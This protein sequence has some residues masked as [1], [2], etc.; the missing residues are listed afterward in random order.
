[1]LLLLR[2]AGR[3]AWR[4]IIRFFDHNGPDRAAAVAYYTLLSLL[5]LLVFLIGLGSFVLGSWDAAYQ[6][7]MFL[8]QGVLAHTD[9]TTLEALRQ[10]A[11]Q[12]SR[13]QA[14][15]LIILAWTSKRV[16][17]SLLT[18]L[19]V[20][21]S[22]PGRSVAKGNLVALAMVGITG[23]GLL[24]TMLL[25]AVAATAEGFV[26]RIAPPEAALMFGGLSA[27]FLRLVLPVAITM[28]FLYILYRTAAPA[29]YTSRHALGGAFLATLL[30]EAAKA[31]FAWYLRNLARYA[32]L[33]GALEGVII[34]ALWVEIS[35][36]I[37]LYGAEVVALT[38]PHVIV[39]NRANREVV[40][41][42]S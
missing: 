40:S 25:A 5:P 23:V 37:V 17:A 4:A 21:F 12:A 30:W 18:A 39:D 28:A 19:E 10:F 34:L 1:V 22:H 15:S 24:L 14:P 6:R 7:A 2:K 8:L 35:V 31:G 26:R 41:E 29:G 16:F 3:I 32:G 13:F 20:V 33:Y 11:E 42:T 38:G 36:S 9:R 27:F